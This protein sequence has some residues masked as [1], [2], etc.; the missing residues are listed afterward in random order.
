MKS[1]RG[2]TVPLFEKKRFWPQILWILA[3]TLGV[4]FG[5]AIASP[6]LIT[7]VVLAAFLGLNEVSRWTYRTNLLICTAAAVAGS[8]AGVFT[9]IQAAFIF[10]LL[11]VVCGY[12]LYFRDSVRRLL[13]YFEEF[14]ADISKGTTLEETVT[15]AVDII[16]AMSGGEAV[17]I[18]VS[19]GE[20]RLYLP[21][22]RD[23]KRINLKCNG[24]AVWKV[25]ASGRPYITNKVDMPKD[26]PLDREAHSLM[27]APMLAR[28][29]KLGVLQM[30]SDRQNA[31]TDADLNKLG[32]LALI[33]SQS[34][35]SYVQEERRDDGDDGNTPAKDDGKPASLAKEDGE[36][37]EKDEGKGNT[38]QS[39]KTSDSVLR[40]KFDL[41]GDEE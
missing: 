12:M 22:Y 20:G 33:V 34:I 36:A 15:L 2:R 26:L 3:L 23:D 5:F 21:E 31:F 13:P 37:P 17:F 35:Y 6:E 27:S 24:G 39:Q 18:A 41:E 16:S 32:V 14:A 29:R 19:D 9:W 28:G 1:G 40:I 38:V 7:A 10:A 30:E 25:F 11:T 4:A 8:V